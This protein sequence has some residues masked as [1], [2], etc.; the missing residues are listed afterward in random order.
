[1]GGQ[2]VAMTPLAQAQSPA[3]SRKPKRRRTSIDEAAKAYRAIHFP[4]VKDEH[5]W[6]T[7]DG[8]WASIPRA[9]G[10]V[11]T[12]VIKEA[13]K[14]KLKSPSAAGV[15]YMTLWLRSQAS[16][17]AR[18]ES[19]SD[20]ALE[21]GYGGERGVTTFRRHLRS[22]KDLGF[23]DY[24]EE[25][26]GRVKWVLLNNPYRVVRQLF[27]EGL[28]TKATFSAVQERAQA[29]GGADEF[30]GGAVALAAAV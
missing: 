7:V 2:A 20:A 5:V 29:V 12:V 17:M 22:L 28:I 24:F 26:R 13:H 6:S 4:T 19:E 23:I 3:G 10:M 15:T 9:L 14:S 27:E 18:I 21:S 11:A 30:D 1:M 16:G 25:S 8:G